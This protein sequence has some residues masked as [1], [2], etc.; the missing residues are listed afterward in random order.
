MSVELTLENG[1]VRPIRASEELRP[2]LETLN[3]DDN[4]FAILA[5]GDEDYIQAGRDSSGFIVEFRRGKATEHFAAAR[6]SSPPTSQRVEPWRNLW[7]QPGEDRFD[8]D[9]TIGLFVAWMEGRETPASIQWV[10]LEL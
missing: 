3:D 2:L 10:R 1:T 7:K 8:L 5:K 4:T 6:T 9:E